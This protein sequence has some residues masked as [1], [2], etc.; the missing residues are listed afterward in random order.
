MLKGLDP[1][2]TPEVLAGSP[3][4]ATASSD[5]PNLGAPPCPR[6]G[7]VLRSGQSIC[8]SVVTPVAQPSRTTDSKERRDD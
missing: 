2:L 1:L 7:L 4:W 6:S 5:R 8:V 3:R